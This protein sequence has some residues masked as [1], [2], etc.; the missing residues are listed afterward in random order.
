ML[1]K[2]ETKGS[3]PWKETKWNRRLTSPLPAH[4]GTTEQQ[5]DPAHNL[6]RCSVRRIAGVGDESEEDSKKIGDEVDLRRTRP[7][8]I[9]DVDRVSEPIDPVNSRH[10]IHVEKP[11][12]TKSTCSIV[13]W[14]RIEKTQRWLKLTSPGRRK[15]NIP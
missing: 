12:E 3:D 9:P 5:V 7:V 6:A 4:P 10:R 1:R 13:S 14:K 15:S 8:E 11:V 2:K